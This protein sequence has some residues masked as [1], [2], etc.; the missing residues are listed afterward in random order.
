[1]TLRTLVV[2]TTLVL[3]T[4]ACSLL[5][6]KQI[7][8]V[9]KPVQLDI[10]QPTLPRDISLQT[11]KWYVV[12]EARIANPCQKVM[13]LNEN[14]EHIVNEDGTHQTTRPKTCEL[15]D[16][17]NPEWPVGYTYLDRFLDDMKDQNSGDVVFVA[18][19]VG[20]YKKMTI[21]NQEIR[22]YIRELG[23]VIIYY[24]DVTLPNGEKGVG[25]EGTK[26][27]N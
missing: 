17:E 7:E 10:I 20:D 16:R 8:V 2:L 22:R 4:S 5:G 18:T 1:M 19:T 6:T 15:E 25:I 26:T 9:S 14:G 21:N 12:S 11:P 27:S 13:R 24:R 23:E 3:T